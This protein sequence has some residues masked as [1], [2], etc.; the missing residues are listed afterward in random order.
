M[1]RYVT[2]CTNFFHLTWSLNPLDLRGSGPT[3]KGLIYDIYRILSDPIPD[4]PHRHSYMDKWDLYLNDTLPLETWQ[5]LWK[6]ATKMSLCVTYRE[7]QFKLLMFW[8]HTPSLLHKLNPNISSLCG[9]CG[10][11]RGTQFYL[12]RNCPRIHPFWVT[13]NALLYEVLGV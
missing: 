5:A 7:N 4:R 13:V 1:S 12:F 9:R 6:R 11:S 10:T 2:I 8:Y 3:T